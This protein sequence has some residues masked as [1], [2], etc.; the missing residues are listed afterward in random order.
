M[1]L[2]FWQ[3]FKRDMKLLLESPRDYLYS[4]TIPTTKYS[5]IVAFDP[6]VK[7][8]GEE[9]VKKITDKFPELPVHF[10]GSASFGI[11][12]QNDIDM[13]I[14]CYPKDFHTYTPFLT[15]LFGQP[16]RVLKEELNWH[17]KKDGIDLE[18]M[19]ID[20]HHPARNTL[21]TTYETLK[22]NPEFL[23]EYEELKLN[24]DGVNL[25]EYKRRRIEFFN[26]IEKLKRK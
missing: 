3:R 19:L 20:P 17:V 22:N 9:L 11:A 18:I 4:F 6:R 2:S 26:K 1:K 12:G 5:K 13:L 15:E 24:S 10:M 8:Y 14:D 25:R 23:K 7:K 21:V 16:D